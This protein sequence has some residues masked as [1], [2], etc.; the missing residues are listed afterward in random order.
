L[1]HCRDW[2]I[3]SYRAGETL[4]EVQGDKQR[5]FEIRIQREDL[6]REFARRPPLAAPR[7]PT[8]IPG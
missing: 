3:G 5:A 6:G 2:I 4:A 8:G 7:E 1:P